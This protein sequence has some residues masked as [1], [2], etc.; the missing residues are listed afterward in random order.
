MDA[1]KNKTFSK[2]VDMYPLACTKFKERVKFKDLDNKN[3][4]IKRAIAYLKLRNEGCSQKIAQP[5]CARTVCKVDSTKETDGPC[6][7]RTLKFRKN[8]SSIDKAPTLNGWLNC[9]PAYDMGT[10]YTSD[11]KEIVKD[12]DQD[13]IALTNKFKLYGKDKMQ[14][15]SKK[16]SQQNDYYKDIST[17]TKFTGLSP[18]SLQKKLQDSKRVLREASRRFHDEHT[19]D[20]GVI[21]PKIQSYKIFSENNDQESSNDNNRIG[22]RRKS[23]GE[24]VFKGCYKRVMN[25]RTSVNLSIPKPGGTNSVRSGM[26][27]AS[28][29]VTLV[30]S[31]ENEKNLSEY[32]R[33]ESLEKKSNMDF[34]QSMTSGKLGKI[35]RRKSIGSSPLGSKF[36]ELGQY[37]S[38][39]H[40]QTENVKNEGIY[41]TQENKQKKSVF[42]NRSNKQILLKSRDLATE[43]NEA[44]YQYM[45]KR[46][47]S[48]NLINQAPLNHQTPLNMN[49]IKEKL[50]NNFIDNRTE[51]QTVQNS[52]VGSK[53]ESPKLKRQDDRSFSMVESKSEV[54]AIQFKYKINKHLELDYGGLSSFIKEPEQFKKYLQSYNDMN[55]YKQP[56]KPV[57]DPK[58]S[59]IKV[60]Q[61]ESKYSA[62][63]TKC[64]LKSKVYADLELTSARNSVRRIYKKRCNLG[65]QLKPHNH[66]KTVSEVIPPVTKKIDEGEN[67]LN[68]FKV[69]RGVYNSTPDQSAER[70]TLMTT[71]MNSERKNLKSRCEMRQ[72]GV[73]YLGLKN[74]LLSNSTTGKDAQANFRNWFKLNVNE[75]KKTQMKNKIS[76]KK[77]TTSEEATSPQFFDQKNCEVEPESAVK[78]QI[79]GDRQ[80]PEKQI[81]GEVKRAPK[82]ITST[83]FDNTVTNTEIAQMQNCEKSRISTNSFFKKRRNNFQS[84]GNTD[85]L[86]HANSPKDGVSGLM[87]PRQGSETHNITSDRNSWRII[88][89]QKEQ[90]GEIKIN[91]SK[92]AKSI[93][94]EISTK[95]QY[96]NGLY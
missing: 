2:K 32:A 67:Y 11:V 65:V 88:T 13:E 84:M 36:N 49:I 41:M 9:L 94:A 76:K 93:T 81:F 42:L 38:Y 82:L 70:L 90:D 12:I 74:G 45:K 66:T 77:D 55:L 95:I 17:R 89:V 34:D 72:G 21:S 46:V 29:I 79:K 3:I 31:P 23:G 52:E 68:P 62:R 26:T 7:F 58:S 56:D 43:F 40:N 30:N 15:F 14:Q 96:N 37:T 71:K 6:L 35:D 86:G 57:T 78:N 64:E 28:K 47:S 53:P 91:S 48:P 22:V 60:N 33:K 25:N 80:N 19:D 10:Q 51:R 75:I 1:G 18:G 5:F 44:N 83:T 61:E 63:H 92:N 69:E 4:D 87:S 85:R 24:N 27:S 50:N 39:L 16:I 20:N 73:N 54:E 59:F 8:S